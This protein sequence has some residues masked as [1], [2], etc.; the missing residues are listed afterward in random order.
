MARLTL[1][2]RISPWSL[3]E[4][5]DPL[6]INLARNAQV[7]VFCFDAFRGPREEPT[8]PNLENQLGTFNMVG[9]LSASLKRNNGHPQTAHNPPVSV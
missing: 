7:L 5:G 8:F 2:W 4:W 1:L 9:I 3:T 6:L